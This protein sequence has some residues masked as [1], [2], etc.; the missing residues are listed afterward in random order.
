MVY[1]METFGPYR[2]HMMIKRVEFCPSQMAV[3][4]SLYLVPN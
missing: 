3:V 4:E 2:G 1:F